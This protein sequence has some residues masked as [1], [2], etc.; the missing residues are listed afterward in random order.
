[1]TKICVVSIIIVSKIMILGKLSLMVIGA[2][3]IKCHRQNERVFIP[4]RRTSNE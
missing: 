4:A 1:M 2:H 3:Y